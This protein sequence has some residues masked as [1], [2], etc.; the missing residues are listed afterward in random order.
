MISF[1]LELQTDGKG[2]LVPPL[3]LQTFIE[4]SIK[5]NVTFIPVLKINVKITQSNETVYI[6]ISDNGLGFKPETL[7]RLMKNEDISA[8]GKH[9]GITNLKQRLQMLYCDNYILIIMQSENL[10]T[11]HIELPALKEDEINEPI[12]SG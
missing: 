5:H 8:D 2:I 1:T 10:T 3:V 7:D 12:V 9:I 6:D 11:I 4:N